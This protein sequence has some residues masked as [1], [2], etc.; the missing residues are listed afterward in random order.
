MAQCRGRRIA[1]QRGTKAEHNGKDKNKDI[2]S[3]LQK[4]AAT[5]APA[6][7]ENVGRDRGE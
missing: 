7:N 3:A 6:S 2:S 4:F 1:A 5:K